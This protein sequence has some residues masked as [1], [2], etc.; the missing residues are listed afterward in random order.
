MQNFS[1]YFP[2]N[3]S[4]KVIK[5]ITFNFEEQLKKNNKIDLFILEIQSMSNN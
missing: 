4:D 1:N 5:S 2:H 3:N